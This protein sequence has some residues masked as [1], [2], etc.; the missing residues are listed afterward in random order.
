MSALRRSDRVPEC[1]I[2]ERKLASEVCA[3][4][5]IWKAS[6]SRE[7]SDAARAVSWPSSVGDTEGDEGMAGSS[8]VYHWGNGCRTNVVFAL[9]DIFFGS[10]TAGVGS[11]A[12]SGFD[13][14]CFAS[15]L[16]FFSGLP[17]NRL[18]R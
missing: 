1:I 10:S 12:G 3:D 17:L 7:C 15:F 14:A 6:M 4:E 2:F 9:S 16:V 13:S 18:E 11:G 8:S 5:E